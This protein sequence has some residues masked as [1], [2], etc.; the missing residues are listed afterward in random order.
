MNTLSRRKL[1][2]S[3]LVGTAGVS[4]IAATVRIA[5]QHGLIPPDSGGIYGCGHTLTYAT[6]RLLTR[7]SNAREF[8]R[9]QIS[10]IPHPKGDPPKGEE[11]PRL[12]VGGFKD[13]RLKIDG[14]VNRPGSLS[15]AELKGSPAR[16]QITQ[17]VCEE[18]WSYIAEWTGVPLSHILNSAGVLPQA[19]FVVYQSM[20]GWLDAIDLDDALHAQ[21]LV[22]YGFNAG[23]LSVG[24]GGPLRMRLPKQ[25]GYKSLKFLNR[26]T[27]TDTLK[28]VPVVGA[29]SWYAGI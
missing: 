2:T 17:L 11:F 14:M 9:N 27:L 8:T 25:L 5:D 20:D 15:I 23:D 28:G 24:H 29:Y 16:S 7:N 26:V 10:K 13:W 19:R 22:T 3:G 12:R 18:G 1:I 4:A 6:Q 21:T